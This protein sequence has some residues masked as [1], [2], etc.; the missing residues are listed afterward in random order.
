VHG[1][2]GEGS[3]GRCELKGWLVEEARVK[4]G[5]QAGGKEGVRG[6]KGAKRNGLAEICPMCKAFIFVC[7]NIL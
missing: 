2:A 7:D 6:T 1:R 4:Q 5:W 3:R